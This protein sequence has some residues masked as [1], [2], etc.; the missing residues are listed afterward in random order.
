MRGQLVGF[1]DA[2]GGAGEGGLLGA[3][4]QVDALDRLVAQP[5]FGGVDDAFE[6]QIVGGRVDEAQISERVADFGALV[7]AE[8][9]DD[10]IG[11]ADGDE[12]VLE[13]ARLE[14]RA[15]EDGGVVEAGALDLQAFERVADAAGFLR[16]VPHALNLAPCRRCR[17]RSTSVLPSRSPLCAM[18]PDAAARMCGVER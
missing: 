18:R 9:A 10:A 7:K 5:A 2:R 3:G 14:L 4:E 17:G 12:A 16:A 15:H 6:R 11:H 13:L 8:T 1:D